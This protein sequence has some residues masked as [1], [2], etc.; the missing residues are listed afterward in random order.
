MTKLRF[1]IL[2][3]SAVLLASCN[4][5]GLNLTDG[6]K[7]ITP[8]IDDAISHY[9]VKKYAT[10]YY[11]TEKQF[12]VH[13]VYG[14]SE[15]DGILSVYMWSYYGGFNQANGLEAQSGHSLPALI[16]L[17]QEGDA[18]SVIDYTEPQDG[19]MYQSSLEKMFPAKYVKSARR[20]NGNIGGLEKKMDKKV[21]A[22]LEKPDS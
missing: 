22:W 11:G 21:K 8:Q 13:K 3:M 16:R 18:Y 5:K 17:K 19:S 9:I 4:D 20:D 15:K 2:V 6:D 1:F 14:T 7:Q 12:E 10:S